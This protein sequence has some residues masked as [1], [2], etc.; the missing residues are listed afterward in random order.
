MMLDFC[1]EIV[2]AVCLVCFL[3]K[4]KACFFPDKAIIMRV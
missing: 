2:Q 1:G 4:D 3:I